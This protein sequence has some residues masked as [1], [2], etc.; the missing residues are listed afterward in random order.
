[1]SQGKR[2]FWWVEPEVLFMS[3]R[4][5]KSNT[6]QD[7]QGDYNGEAIATVPVTLTT[8]AS[9]MNLVWSTFELGR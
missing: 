1:M 3:G 5:R 4:G 7:D 8:P 6:P 2:G 9:F